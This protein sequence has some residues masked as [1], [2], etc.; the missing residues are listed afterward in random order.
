MD[1]KN[2]PAWK[3]QIVDLL[4]DEQNGYSTI[5]RHE[6][7][8]HTSIFRGLLIGPNHKFKSITRDLNQFNKF[9]NAPF[10]EFMRPVPDDVT[11]VE[12]AF[13]RVDF[14]NQRQRTQQLVGEI[15]YTFPSI[16]YWIPRNLNF[17]YIK[18]DSLIR[19][20]RVFDFIKKKLRLG[21]KNIQLDSYMLG[22][23]KCL[24]ARARD[25]T[26][27]L[28]SVLISTV[29]LEDET[30]ALCIA[31]AHFGHFGFSNLGS[32]FDLKNLISRYKGELSFN[33]S[34]AAGHFH[35]L[36]GAEGG[37]SALPINMSRCE[38]ITILAND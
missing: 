17:F 16:E 5:I 28:A 30:E 10:V 14:V 24:Y 29:D 25:G 26:E 19:T 20:D 9:S 22:D 11:S 13:Q 2:I 6:E 35:L 1:Q 15:I 32:I 23:Q 38:V 36:Y 4:F 33:W 31:G 3:L 21:S 27:I 18:S 8:K 7:T 34:L 12:A 37:D